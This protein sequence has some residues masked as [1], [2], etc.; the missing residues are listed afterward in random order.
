MSSR[1][2]I[3]KPVSL[4]DKTKSLQGKR[5][6]EPSPSGSIIGYGD[7][8]TSATAATTPPGA[9]GGH[10]TT[11]AGGATTNTTQP[12]K[13][14]SQIP[15]L[16]PMMTQDQQTAAIQAAAFFMQMQGWQSANTKDHPIFDGKKEHFNTFMEKLEA[17]LQD[18]QLWD[19]VTE[20]N[21]DPERNHALYR[22][23][24]KCL[25]ETSTN[26][27][28]TNA[29]RDGKGAL[30]VLKTHHQGDIKARKRQALL[31][32]HHLK[33]GEHEEPQKFLIRTDTLK[34]T[35]STLDTFRDDEMLIISVIEALPE[36]Q[37]F[38]KVY[39]R[40]DTSI[41]TYEALRS[42]I[43]SQTQFDKLTSKEST[44]DTA[45]SISVA[46]SIPTRVNGPRKQH[47]GSAS[48]RGSRR[49]HR[50]KK[51]TP[52]RTRLY[53]NHCSKVGHHRGVCWVLNPALRSGLEAVPRSSSSGEA[54]ARG[55][56]RG[57]SPRARM[58]WSRGGRG[59]G[60]PSRSAT[61]AA[62]PDTTTS[63]DLVPTTR[64]QANYY[65]VYPT[66]PDPFPNQCA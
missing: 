2:K 56:A 39:L 58:F 43:A 40:G 9:A 61:S 46:N 6:V 23:I 49:H 65:G 22:A 20:D 59:G 14:A 63:T 3:N 12:Q 24:I 52:Y 11:P 33:M 57:R 66:T 29:K 31:D 53:C 26:I 54:T 10:G 25:D 62:G 51:F 16:I 64:H 30:E 45:P 50:G 21:P 55:G 36:S 32:L 1:R 13:T 35:L 5:V 7:T 34:K 60:R 44:G 41:D 27:V 37:K 18:I 28:S 4:S 38:L 15:P 47:R 42:S 19:V 8:S 17:Y 48:Y